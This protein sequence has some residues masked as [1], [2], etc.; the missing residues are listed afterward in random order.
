MRANARLQGERVRLRDLRLEDV[1]DV[2]AY[3]SDQLVARSAGWKPHRTLHD[4][5]AY[6]ERCLHHSW[7]PITFA[8]ELVDERRV[9]GVVDIRIVD[10]LWGVGE[11]GYTLARR[12]WGRGFNVEAGTL[13][14]DYGFRQLGLS[15]I[16]AVCDIGNRRSYRTMEKLGMIRE[17]VIPRTASRPGCP[18][19]RFVYSVIYRE[20]QRRHIQSRP[21]RYAA[22]T[23]A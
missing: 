21:L 1:G 19:D 7:A 14:I 20:W 12:G 3:A 6:I 8:V 17:G 23:G 16:R 4:S 11:I 22:A 2:Y 9:I 15:R 10:R 18:V 5:R 13:L